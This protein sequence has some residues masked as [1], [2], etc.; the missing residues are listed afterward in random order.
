MNDMSTQEAL[1]M[2]MDVSGVIDINPMMK[3]GA[4][5]LDSLTMIEWVSMLEEKLEVELDIRD[6]DIPE[7]SGRSISDV[8]D[9][10]R[11]RAVV[12]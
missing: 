4:L 3:F 9:I 12:V 1:E 5:Q 2:L 11:K 10:L 7:L 8:L 6:L